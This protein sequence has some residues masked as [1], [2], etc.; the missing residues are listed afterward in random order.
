MFV[1]SVH[2][3]DLS[4]K[5]FFTASEFTSRHVKEMETQVQRIKNGLR[6][7]EGKNGW[8]KGEGDGGGEG[9]Q[10]KTKIEGLI[11]NSGSEEHYYF[12]SSAEVQL[13]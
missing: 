12:I 10:K 6:R 4:I 2:H 11:N 3:Q 9:R 5:V 1:I 8:M 7:T 13:Q